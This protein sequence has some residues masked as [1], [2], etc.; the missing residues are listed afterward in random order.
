[1][2][3]LGDGVIIS[4]GTTSMADLDETMRFAVVELAASKKVTLNIRKPIESVT[5]SKENTKTGA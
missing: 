1:M 5:S 3:L 2:A 4:G